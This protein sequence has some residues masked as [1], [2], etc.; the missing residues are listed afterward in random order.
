MEE[1]LEK[2]SVYKKDPRRQVVLKHQYCQSEEWLK[3]EIVPALV[4]WRF[5]RKEVSKEVRRD[6][7]RQFLE[8]KNHL[9][10]IIARA[11]ILPDK[12]WRKILWVKNVDFVDYEATLRRMNLL[13]MDEISKA[14]DSLEGEKPKVPEVFKKNFFDWI[15][16]LLGFITAKKLF[17]GP[18][19][20]KTRWYSKG[21]WAFNLLSLDFG[22]SMYPQGVSNDTKITNKSFSRF[23]SI[24]EHINDFIVNKEDGLYWKLYR[25]ARSNFVW[26]PK[27]KVELSTHVCPGFW[28]TLLLHLWF[29]VVS[30]IGFMMTVVLG[31]SAINVGNISLILLFSVTPLWTLIASLKVA[32][33]SLYKFL[34][35]I[36][37][38]F[39]TFALKLGEK[40]EKLGDF[41]V[42]VSEIKI[43]KTISK[44]FKF[45]GAI[46]VII[47]IIVCTI[48]I[49]TLIWPA[50]VK[51]FWFLVGITGSLISSIREYPFSYLLVLFSLVTVIFSLYII[52]ETDLDDEKY[53]KYDK[54]VR[55]MSYAWFIGIAS[56]FF[57]VFREGVFDLGVSSLIISIPITL[58]FVLIL[59]LSFETSQINMGTLEKRLDSKSK[60]NYFND[61]IF[62]SSKHKV[63]KT[64]KI[65]LKNDWVMKIDQVSYINSMSKLLKVI[66]TNYDL[67]GG[68]RDKF[69]RI[70][71]PVFNQNLLE[72]LERPIPK[73][74]IEPSD[75]FTFLYWIL[76]GFSF[77]EATRETRKSISS[78]KRKNE[79]K[80]KFYGQIKS[81]LIVLYE[82]I[83]K[84]IFRPFIY[85]FYGIL[86]VIYFLGKGISNVLN[87]LRRFFLTLK[88]VWSLFN[89]RCPYISKSEY[90]D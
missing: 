41:L 59:I 5:V 65:I 33:K 75:K 32:S 87:W 26:F 15:L 51:F 7:C 47:L 89:E 66:E 24:K 35:L 43:F 13:Q 3:R 77:K 34:V 12:V 11:E 29:W 69:L 50:L 48:Y 55:F 86:S 70:V 14:F 82:W 67:S 38:P 28:K 54:V 17:A 78:E 68:D 9:I 60:A 62:W 49:S 84:W 56:L 64:Q 73:F 90:L 74:L 83:A 25:S 79:V 30:P 10:R 23:L 52:R 39:K 19:G 76:D 8:D 63:S 58:A 36:A 18:Y 4:F 72:K 44:I 71:L 31:N 21:A 85:L 88:D 16:V 22:F 27:K 57:F 37:P 61:F 20:K 53:A 42:S 46:L 80:S 40:M 45:I 2:W 1:L 6:F 81:D